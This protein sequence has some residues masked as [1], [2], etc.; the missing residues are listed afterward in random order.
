MASR[1]QAT[2]HPEGAAHRQDAGGPA[3][4]ETVNLPPRTKILQ[5]DSIWFQTAFRQPPGRTQSLLQTV[6]SHLFEKKL[7]LALK[8]SYGTPMRGRT[9]GTLVP[10]RLRVVGYFVR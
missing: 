8:K 7:I 5:S 1:K 3:G 4:L 2:W 10:G 9:A 6:R